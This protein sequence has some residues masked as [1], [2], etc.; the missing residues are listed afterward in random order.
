MKRLRFLTTVMAVVFAL[1]SAVSADDG[2]ITNKNMSRTINVPDFGQPIVDNALSETEHAF[3]DMMG[4]YVPAQEAS[5]LVGPI[6]YCDIDNTPAPGEDCTNAVEELAVAKPLVNVFIYGP[7]F[8]VLD[9]AFGHSYMDTY[10]AIS[11]NDGE[12]WKQEN[13]SESADRSSFNL[14]TDHNTGG[15][16][17]GDGLPG[18][19]NIRLGNAYH[20]SGYLTPYTAHCSECHGYGLQGLGEVPSCYS[21]HD[22]KWEED[23]PIEIGPVVYF[24]ELEGEDK[25]Q[26]KLKVNGENAT[27]KAEVSIINAITGDLVGTIVAEKDGEFYYSEKYTDSLPPCVVKAE[28]KYDGEILSSPT[29][30]VKNKMTG[31]PIEN[32]EGSPV[33]LTVYP[34][35]AYN[36]F[37][38]TAGNKTLVAWPSRFCSSGQPAYSMTT[39]TGLEDPDQQ[40]R[41]TAITDFLVAGDTDLGVDALPDF[42][43]ENDLY[44]VDAFGV[45]GTQGS[46]DFTD[47]GYPQA[48]VVPFG[49]VWTARGVLLPGDDPRTDELEF[50][51]MVWTKAERLTSGRRDPNRIEVHAVKGAGFVITWQEDPEGMRPGQGLG[52]GEGW[53]GAVA[54]PRTDAWYSFINEEY[55]DI[56]ETLSQ[57]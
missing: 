11:L 5:G 52:P 15:R 3:T 28:Y 27:S 48:G 24:A 45:A 51:H 8:H 14:D 23:T 41:L 54:H 40:A 21:C 4:F 12:N 9:T 49:C 31:E 42:S 37:H 32:C 47:E 2:A 17:S 39:E 43:M 20:D 53:S 33:N 16:K 46:I 55:F 29:L 38:A 30:A 26:S 56:V 34:G 1:S 57:T 18:D 7:K 10:A 13:L 19:H 50:S 6:A 35:G 25:K 44:L 36:V 22:K